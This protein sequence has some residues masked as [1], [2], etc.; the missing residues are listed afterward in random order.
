MKASGQQYRVE[1]R[2]IVPGPA[3]TQMCKVGYVCAGPDNTEC[4]S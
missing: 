2:D 1:G 3:R 4:K